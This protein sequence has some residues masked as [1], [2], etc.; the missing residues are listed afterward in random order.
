MLLDIF[1]Q[2]LVVTWHYVFVLKS[3]LMNK[4][5]VITAWHLFYIQFDKNCASK[6][7]KALLSQKVAPLYNN[8][9]KTIKTVCR[10]SLNSMM[11]TAFLI[12]S[13]LCWQYWQSN[14]ENCG[15]D[16]NKCK[17]SQ[18]SLK[19]LYN[20]IFKTFKIFCSNFLWG[21]GVVSNFSWFVVAKSYYFN[22]SSQILVT[23]GSR[24]K[25]IAQ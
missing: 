18:K 12:F 7:F 5:F 21:K 4:Y 23:F 8:S 9:S 15:G 14:V 3:E 2:A 25:Y 16:H 19:K 22:W 24:L 6:H 17:K 10:H 13:W 11:T 20:A 1:L